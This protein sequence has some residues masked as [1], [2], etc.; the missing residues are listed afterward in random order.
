MSYVK[1]FITL[2]SVFAVLGANPSFAKEDT[3]ESLA[4]ATKVS[5]EKVI[6]LM[7]SNADLVVIDSRKASDRA[8]GFIEG[9]I[10]LP[11]TDTTEASLASHIKSKSTPVTFYCNGVKCGRSYESAKIAIDLGYKNVFWFR[12]GWD[13]WTQKGLPIMKN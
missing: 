8:K 1:Q 11:N 3:P 9:S 13:E 12:G 7:Q 10:G 5:A 4:G 2:L 6:E